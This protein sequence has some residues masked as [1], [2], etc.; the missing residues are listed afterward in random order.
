MV[1]HMH[2]L[3]GSCSQSGCGAH[4]GATPQVSCA[5][6]C[7]AGSL[8]KICAVP[9][10]SHQA[11]SDAETA[12]HAA[13]EALGCFPSAQHCLVTGLPLHAALQQGI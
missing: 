5:L 1:Q 12:L 4:K 2:Q 13:K 3:Q 11:A 9:T 6:P 8:C 7:E 10:V